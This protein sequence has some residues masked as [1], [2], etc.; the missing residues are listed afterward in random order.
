MEM[1]Y[2]PNLTIA[3][4]VFD[5][6]LSLALPLGLMLVLMGLVLLAGGMSAAYTPEFTVDPLGWGFA[7]FCVYLFIPTV[8]HIKEAVTW[9]ILRSGI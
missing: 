6:L 8:L 7:A 4:L 5:V 9:R 2:I 3:V 1:L